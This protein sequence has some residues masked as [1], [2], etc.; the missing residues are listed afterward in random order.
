MPQGTVLRS[1]TVT[2]LGFL[3]RAWQLLPRLTAEHTARGVTPST[4]NLKSVSFVFLAHFRIVQT[5]VWNGG[6]VSSC[7]MLCFRE[8]MWGLPANCPRSLR[9]GRGSLLLV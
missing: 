1:A 4:R 8:K 3:P 7:V 5:C 9:K 2:Y 6:H